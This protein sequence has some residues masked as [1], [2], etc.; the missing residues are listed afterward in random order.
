[1]PL[2]AGLLLV[3]QQRRVPVP[4]SAAPSR[5]HALDLLPDVLTRLPALGPA[6]Q[7]LVVAGLCVTHM[8]G[9]RELHR[10]LGEA[11]G[12]RRAAHAPTVLPARVRGDALG[13]IGRTAREHLANAFRK[14]RH[15]RRIEFHSPLHRAL[16][17]PRPRRRVTQAFDLGALQ[18]RFRH[19]HALPLVPL[20]RAN[21]LEHHRGQPGVRAGA[22]RKRRI[23]RGQEHEVVEIPT[24]EAEG[25]AI[26]GQEDPRLPPE[27]FATLVA[28]RLPYRDEDA[29]VASART[30]AGGARDR[31]PAGQA[32]TITYSTRAMSTTNRYCAAIGIQVPRLEVA[33]N[34]PDANYYSLLI[35]ALLERGEPITLEHA[36]KRFEAAG[37]APPGRALASLKR[38][39]PARPPIYRDGNLYALDP[40]DDEVDLWAFRLGL[41]PPE[42]PGLQVLPPDPD[43]L[44]SPDEPLTVAALDEAWREGVPTSWSALRIAICVLDAHRKPM[45]PEDVLAF[46]RAR[47]RWHL[48]SADSAQYWRRG[49]AVCVRENELWELDGGHAAVRSARQAVRD[50]IAVVRRWAQLRPDSAIIEE[51]SKRLARAREANAERLARMH[52]VL[53]H[54]FPPQKPAAVVLVDVNRREIGTFMGEDITAATAK[55]AAY[56]IIAAVDVRAL[57]RTLE[58]EP[59]ERRLAELGPPQKTLQVNRWGRTLKVTTTLL[60][61]SSCGISH[62]FADETVLRRYLRDGDDA[63]L[64]RRLEADAKA[65][66][67]LY[68]YGRLHG[69][70]RLRWG[71]LDE[72]LPAP[73]VHRD[74][75]TL[76]DLVQRAHEIGVPLEV[77]IG[78]APGWADPWSRAQ[79]VYVRKE[80]GGWRSWLIDEQ[81]FRIDAA[82]IQG[83]R[84]VGADRGAK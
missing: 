64:C 66:F 9:D 10:L 60:V 58:F 31:F 33:K 40:F 44:P 12:G 38:C 8:R 3:G 29:E 56:D 22:P 14:A 41:R 49:S 51:N 42:A 18:R 50:R 61:Q 45:R 57:L 55:L 47:S 67:A 30:I 71:F 48:L 6:L 37:I 62:P 83:A 70:L 1:V 52:R 43:P 20:P 59:G 27:R 74:E 34:S 81:G 75:H 36:A 5:Q 26:P 54:A 35:V 25:A 21:P 16:A 84:L 53:L 39:K 65:L 68:Q 78:S 76:Y 32:V 72:R 13:A 63:K 19:Q 7:E 17:P 79:R 28:A 23:A 2:R 46:V 69:A 73:W 80:A 4:L 15:E 82:D 11:L 77:V 24:G